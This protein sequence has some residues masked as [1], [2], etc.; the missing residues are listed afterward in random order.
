MSSLSLPVS[1][2]KAPFRKQRNRA[3]NPC[4]GE[5]LQQLPPSILNPRGA[6]ELSPLLPTEPTPTLARCSRRGPPTRPGG[7]RC[8]DMRCVAPFF[9]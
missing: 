4:P 2:S 9:L 1:R 3:K 6:A 5:N 7:S 8:P